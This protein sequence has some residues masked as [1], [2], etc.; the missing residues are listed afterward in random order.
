MY[1]SSPVLSGDLLF[2]FSHKN[3]G[4]FFCLDAR[5]GAARWI[6][7]PRQGDNAAMVIAGERLLLL[8]DNA[9]LIL[10][11]ASAEGFKPERRYTV[12]DSP[13][14]AHP[15]ILQNGIVIKDADSLAFWSFR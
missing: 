4:Q 5:T 7:E 1:M 13:T 2:G 8:K 3:K 14:W 9:E 10:A 12:A 15:L 11:R 6:G